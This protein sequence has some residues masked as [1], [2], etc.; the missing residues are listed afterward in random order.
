MD[1]QVD[2]ALRGL[3]VMVKDGHLK[4]FA[5]ANPEHAPYGR[6]A[7][8]ALVHAGLWESIRRQL[9]FG[10]NISQAAQFALSGATQGG[11]LAY[12]LVR[13]PPFLGRGES[14]LVPA[15]WHRPLRQRMALLKGA[16]PAARR[17]YH[18]I[19]QPPA[20]DILRRHG[21]VLPDER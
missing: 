8:E 12:S 20:R 4:H 5:I 14:V 15:S 21:F 10:E 2:T 13:S 9:V 18:Y 11:L 6:A 17:F 3:G 19:Q 16:G 1:R 7:R